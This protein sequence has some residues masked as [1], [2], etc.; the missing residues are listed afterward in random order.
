MPRA[1]SDC[2]PPK[3]EIA[4]D[5][6]MAVLEAEQGTHLEKVRRRDPDCRIDPDRCAT[7]CP[8]DSVHLLPDF[9]NLP[10]DLHMGEAA[11]VAV[12]AKVVL[13]PASARTAFAISK[14]F[15]I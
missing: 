1:F 13:Y 9:L 2:N 6:R 4:R 5:T 10:K 14:R 7:E 15:L 8:G 3:R 12:N 11:A